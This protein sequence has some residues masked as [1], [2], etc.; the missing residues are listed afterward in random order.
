M[1]MALRGQSLTVDVQTNANNPKTVQSFSHATTHFRP[2]SARHPLWALGEATTREFSN[3]AIPGRVKIAG[4]ASDHNLHQGVL[5][6]MAL[7]AAHHITYLIAR[8]PRSGHRPTMAQR[9]N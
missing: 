6:T 8:E 7:H 1:A 2:M 4:S 5:Q 3:I 9:H